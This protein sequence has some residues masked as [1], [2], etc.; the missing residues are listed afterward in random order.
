MKTCN[1][2]DCEH[3]NYKD[4]VMEEFEI[5]KMLHYRGQI[6]Y[7]NEVVKK[8]PECDKCENCIVVLTENR[9]TQKRVC[10]LSKRIIEKKILYSPNWCMKKGGFNGEE[11]CV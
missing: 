2:P 1:Y 5:E 10:T 3:C 7:S 8:M 4:C 9:R 11:V 6:V